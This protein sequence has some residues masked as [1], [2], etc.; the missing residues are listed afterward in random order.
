[1]KLDPLEVIRQQL[2]QL[3]RE[4]RGPGLAKSGSS[5]VT[6]ES[7]SNFDA[8][9]RFAEE[10]ERIWPKV[11][12]RRRAARLGIHESTLRGWIRRDALDRC[13]TQEAF[14]KLARYAQYADL[15]LEFGGRS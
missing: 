9:L 10:L 13:P 6:R 14:E 1:V 5:S 8:K 2:A 4:R 11:S 3:E 15:A 7:N 12:Q